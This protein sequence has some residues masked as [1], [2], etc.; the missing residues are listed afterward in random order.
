[1]NFL[2]S[3]GLHSLGAERIGHLLLA[4]SAFQPFAAALLGL[5][6]NCAASV[7]LTELYLADVLSFG[8]M[9]AGLCSNAGVG[10]AVLFR[11]NRDQRENGGIVAVL[12]LTAA[13]SGLLLQLLSVG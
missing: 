3:L 5:I 11:M 4:G 1:M 10:L 8:A 7:M 9:A 12:Y 13:F 2:L 6:P